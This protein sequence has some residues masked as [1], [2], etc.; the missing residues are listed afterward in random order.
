MLKKLL[1][2]GRTREIIKKF[3][4]EARQ[5]AGHQLNRVQHRK[6]PSDWKPM[7][8][9]GPGVAEIRIH[10]PF[11]HRVIYVVKFEEGIYVLH[12]FAKKTQKTHEKD[13]EAAR[14]AFKE[15]IRRRKS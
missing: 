7:P 2:V 8:S 10:H 6:E 4:V 5:E 1:W 14:K 11:E 15:I 9:I 3:P 13:L 12:A